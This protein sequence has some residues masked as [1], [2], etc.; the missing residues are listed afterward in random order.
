MALR[1]YNLL[2]KTIFEYTFILGIK[3]IN[4]DRSIDILA[5][6][7]DDQ[8]N[9]ESGNGLVLWNTKLRLFQIVVMIGLWHHTVSLDHNEYLTTKGMIIMIALYHLE[10]S[11]Y[12]FQKDKCMSHK[13]NQISTIFIQKDI[14]MFHRID[15]ICEIWM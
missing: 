9:N 3:G 7:A 5:D 12:I 6:L 13:F 15:Q 4:T 14:S 1:E 11:I 10:N 8:D 2:L